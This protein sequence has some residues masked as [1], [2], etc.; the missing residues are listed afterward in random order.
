MT[1]LALVDLVGFWVGI[2]LTLCI[3]SFLYKDNPFYKTA[4]HLFIGIAA[5]Y[6]MVISFDENLVPKLI[7][8]LGDGKWIRL[9]ALLLLLMM[10][11]KP[12]SQRLGWMGRYPLAIVVAFAAGTQINAV[13]QSDLGGQIK[14]ASRTLSSTKL[15][16]NTA[17]PEQIAGLPGMSPTMA[18]KLVK[19]REQ[20]PFTSL[21]DMIARP[22]LTTDERTELSSR[23]GVLVGLDAKADVQA[24]Q[25]SSFG[26]F[27]NVLLLMGLLSSLL[28]FYFSLA[29][30]GVVGKVSRFGVWVIMIGFGASF[31][32][33]V[34]GRIAL[35]IGRAQDIRGTFLESQDASQI[36]GPTVAVISAVIIIVGI[37]WWELQNR[38]QPSGAGGSSGSAAAG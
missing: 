17:A 20:K 23:R 10:F 30:R 1:E 36:Q 21:D 6:A 11:A 9:V 38:R 34:Q 19:E 35:A 16:L 2:F 15:D 27:S 14:F 28:Y 24:N 37:V 29:H 5:G 3:L 31:G 32:Y 7:G 4:E 12:L 33:T 25:S 13:A 8:A 26:V 22:G 18:R